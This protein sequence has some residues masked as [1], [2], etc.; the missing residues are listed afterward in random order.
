MEKDREENYLA[1]GQVQ[2]GWQGFSL[3]LFV[4]PMGKMQG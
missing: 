3:V 1:P 4:V 2:V